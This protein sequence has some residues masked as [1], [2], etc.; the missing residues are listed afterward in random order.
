MNQSVI[1]ALSILDLFIEDKE[2]SLQEIARKADIPKPTAY[3]LLSTLEHS[4]I[5]Y[6][7]KENP[8]D[9][10][11]GLGLKLLEYGNLVSERLELRDIAL[12]FMEKFAEEINEVV[13]LVIAYQ[14]EAT[15]IEKVNS[16]RALSLHTKIGRSTPLYVG[17][18]PKMLLAFLPEQEQEQILNQGE[19]VTLTNQKIDKIALKQELKKIRKNQFAISIGE[20][21]ADTTGV[22]FPIFNHEGKVIAALAVSG[23]SSRFMGERLENIK[24]SGTTF[25]NEMSKQ[26]GYRY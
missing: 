23:L 5:L 8:H 19:L 12:P 16:K 24:D 10:R 11:Y 6:K 14:Q 25:A 21:D 1:K 4:G 26:L 18:G 13:H 15:Y 2:L 3:R 17:S 20:Q 22:S 9:S 7:L